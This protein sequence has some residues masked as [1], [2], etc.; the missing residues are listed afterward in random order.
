MVRDSF[1]FSRVSRD[2]EEMTVLRGFLS[3]ALRSPKRA[4]SLR[5]LTWRS[6]RL[7]L[8]LLKLSSSCRALELAMLGHD[9]RRS[10][11]P[12]SPDEVSLLD[13]L[14]SPSMALPKP[15]ISSQVEDETAFGV[16]NG[17]KI[18]A[19]SFR[20]PARLGKMDERK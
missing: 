14:T 12:E 9:L 10:S 19:V 20:T 16:L 4:L 18:G 3:E 13:V 2:L 6:T 8:L 17:L 7:R 5:C 1:S 11:P 15:S